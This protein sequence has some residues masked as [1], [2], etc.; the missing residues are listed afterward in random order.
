MGGGSDG[1]EERMVEV[2][3]KLVIMCRKKEKAF[4]LSMV[5][6]IILI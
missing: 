5:F 1:V 3:M 2:A 4:E 6:D